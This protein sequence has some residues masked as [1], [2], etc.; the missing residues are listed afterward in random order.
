MVFK[1][2]AEVCSSDGEML[3][4]QSCEVPKEESRLAPPQERWAHES[5]NNMM[6]GIIPRKGILAEFQLAL[7]ENLLRRS[8]YTRA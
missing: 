5:H 3:E 8:I 4:P 6:T 1:V 2:D 7:N